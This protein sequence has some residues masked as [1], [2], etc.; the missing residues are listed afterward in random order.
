MAT[1]VLQS[2]DRQIDV[3]FS[4]WN[5]AST[6]LAVVS[7]I[8]LFYPVFF[9]AQADVHPF[10]LA[11]QAHASPVRK[12]GESA[13]YRA[14]ETPNGFPLRSGLN[15]KDEGAPAWAPGK[16][17]DLRHVWR[18]ATKSK[19]GQTARVLSIKGKDKPVQHELSEITATIN[20]IGSHIKKQSGTRVAVCLPNSVELLITILGAWTDSS[21]ISC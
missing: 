14:P 5:V 18:E 1:G 13:I 16:D 19:N 3:F 21:M 15:V 2:I 4:G 7:I 17:G 6:V 8:V 10:I 12:P 11:R 20:I 9:G